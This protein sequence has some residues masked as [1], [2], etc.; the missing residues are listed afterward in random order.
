M[1]YPLK[2]PS[3]SLIK[4]FI[5][6][7]LRR[8]SVGDDS[9]VIR[10]YETVASENDG[11]IITFANVSAMVKDSKG[12]RL[13]LGVSKSMLKQVSA[14]CMMREVSERFYQT[15]EAAS[16]PI[17][18]FKFSGMMYANS[19]AAVMLEA[20]NA[21]DLYSHLLKDF[22]RSDYHDISNN[23][24]FDLMNNKPISASEQVW[25]TLSGKEI[26]VEV[27][28][29]R[30]ELFSEDVFVIFVLDIT[31][32]KKAQNDILD[33]NR[34]ISELYRLAPYALGVIKNAR[35][36]EANE[37]FFEMTGYQPSELLGKTLENVHANR[38]EYLK[39]SETRQQ[40]FTEGNLSEI[41]SRY[42]K[43]DGSIID[44][45]IRRTATPS[46]GDDAIIFCVIDITG[47]KET[48]RQLL[49]TN[50]LIR[51]LYRLSPIGLGV[52]NKGILVEGNDSLYELTEYP[53]EELLGK[54][55]RDIHLSDNDFNDFRDK[56]LS[57]I[58]SSGF[59]EDETRYITKNGSAKDVI[60]R[61]LNTPSLGKDMT[62]FSVIDI[63]RIRNAEREL[64]SLYED[65]PVAMILLD[66]DFNV[67]RANRAA[68]DFSPSK[69]NSKLNVHVGNFLKCSS[70]SQNHGK[71]DC[72]KCELLSI[73]Y[74]I[75]NTGK[76][77]LDT[78]INVELSDG[79]FKTSKTLSISL[80][81]ITILG[82][83]LILFCFNDVSEKRMFEKRFNQLQKL[84][85]SGLI[86]SGAAHDF[87]NVLAA[88]SLNLSYLL[89]NELPA[90]KLRNELSIMNDYVERGSELT[91]RLLSMG[92][93][94]YSTEQSFSI[95]KL[96]Q[97]LQIMIQKICGRKIRINIISPCEDITIF[98]D[99]TMIEQM[100][101]NLSLNGRDA[102]PDGGVLTI[103]ARYAK[104]DDLTDEHMSDSNI[105]MIIVSDTG[106][107]IDPT[108]KD[109]I[110]EPFFTTKHSE[111]CGG[112]GL[113][114]VKNTADKHN[115]W[116]DIKSEVG[117][118]TSISVYLPV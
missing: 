52:M 96:L 20:E 35:L 67:R 76:A 40:L 81:K 21:E 69:S 98:A 97:N 51:D 60:V 53:P 106:N 90:D 92:R 117:K 28:S 78:D 77:I 91:R 55:F 75:K 108:I 65:A 99:K 26:T 102:M 89:D 118:G 49:K 17:L 82:E 5:Q 88:I 4:S 100:I 72:S 19:A 116:I 25:L 12:K 114:I 13:Y 42:K 56:I 45:I 48:E 18:V 63:T 66:N 14:D 29:T 43:K 38:A 104:K 31:A 94:N 41:E 15:L 37:R 73:L 57:Q 16:V 27:R 87:N 80:S 107:G 47:I 23:R 115:G 64:L 9:P 50:S 54:S 70:T 11:N 32:R 2:L 59:V 46:L 62:I 84:E 83:Q 71:K 22:I 44:V 10:Y 61:L 33:I 111:E 6:D 8:I 79:N 93:N 58:S 105:L 36:T 95:N 34:H 103:E 85:L 24:L 113:S 68:I 109:R 3:W 1:E 110:F 74:E 7:D 39:L 86:A 112:L 101:L 30:V